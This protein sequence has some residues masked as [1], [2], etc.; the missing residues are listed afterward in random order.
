MAFP[1]L[2]KQSEGLKKIPNPKDFALEDVVT[3][4]F[5]SS[6]EGFRDFVEE[7][8]Y[9]NKY[10][11][12]YDKRDDG[13]RVLDYA[14]KIT[15][16]PETDT[17]TIKSRQEILQTFMAHPNLTNLV[18]NKTIR[19]SLRYG[20]EWLDEFDI[21]IERGREFL[22]YVTELA[23]NLPESK[24]PELEGFRTYVNTLVTEGGRI[25]DLS[26]ILEDI[27]KN[28]KLTVKTKFLGKK[29]V[30][31]KNKIDYEM[32]T[33]EVEG[34]LASGIQKTTSDREDWLRPSELD[35]PYQKLFSTIVQ[36]VKEKGG[37]NLVLWE[38]PAEVKIEVDQ[39]RETVTG[40]AT[41]YKLNLLGTL[42]SFRKK[43]KPVETDLEFKA[44]DDVYSASF[45][46]A[47]RSLKS[48]VYSDSLAEYDTDIREFG[49]AV[50]E[51]RYLAIAADYFN[52]LR[53]QGVQ[54]TMPTI[55]EAGDRKMSVR[56]LVEPN[57]VRKINLG[58]IVAND[59]SAE[60]SKN[61]YIITGPNNNG[62]TTYMN[63]LGIAQAMGQAGMMILG[64]EATIS[65]RDNIF[66]HYI[67]PGDLVA[68][69]S[70]YAHELSRIKGITKRAT[71]NSLILL[72]EPCSGTSPKDARQEADAVVRTAGDLGAT[73]YVTTHF[74]NLINTA[75]ELP[76][77]RNLH[78]VAK[79]DGKDLVYT[80]KITEGGSIQSNG[81]YLAR[82][83][84]A[85]RVGLRKVL[86][87]R[88]E[89]EGLQ[90]RE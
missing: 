4:M 21:R 50:V 33:A 79:G 11:D 52:Q 7:G 67:R 71:G 84:G 44:E 80:Y 27:K 38:T 41:Y 26:S 39:E 48:L 25:R 14:R 2:V 87:E 73:T 57:L 82:K 88:V 34:T 8:Y 56:N 81:E 65:P 90:L 3:G 85:D 29:R 72:D 83:M 30:Y 37:R 43:I 45:S 78:C 32:N 5:N 59:I 61:L 63:A 77:G 74:H 28:G 54:T 19:K 9:P 68:G 47:M 64:K 6:I 17:A 49:N 42:F 31:N 22:S 40:K 76:Y 66:T 13:S 75:K 1:T 23:Q 89:K 53:E 18:L 46:K 10:D 62:K 86:T 35:I 36:Q 70:R 58:D 15:E 51:L 60:V 20:H 55:V 24:N 12:E 69:E 16:H